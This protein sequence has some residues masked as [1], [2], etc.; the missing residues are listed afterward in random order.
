[1]DGTTDSTGVIPGDATNGLD[2][3]PT[4][5]PIDRTASG[6]ITAAAQTVSINKESG[7]GVVGI[8]IT[9][10]WT[11]TIEFE[12]TVDGS[13]WVALRVHDGTQVVTNTTANGLFMAPAGHLD[14]VRVRSS[15]Y[16][17]GTAN[18]NLLS[19][20]GVPASVITAPLPAGTNNIGDVDIA[21]ALPAGTNNIGDVDVLTQPARSHTTDSIRIGD[22]TDLALVTGAGALVVDGSGVTQP[23]SGTVSANLNAGT[24]NIGDVDIASP[25]GG[26]TEAAA[27]RVTIANDSTGVVSVDDNGGSLTVDVGSALPAGTNNI[28]DVDIASFAS[29]AITEVQGDVAHDAAVGGNP[30]L[31]G[32]RANANEPTAVADGDATHIWADTFG[33]QV[34]IVGHPSTEAP[35]TANGSAAGVSVIAAPGAGVSLH[36]CKGSVHNSAAAE[37]IVSLREGTAGTIRWT[38]NLAADGGGSLFDFGSRGWKLPA[39]TALIMDAASA[40]AYC[41]ITE[42]YIAP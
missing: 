38:V 35:V 24:N 8:Q 11:A 16:T 20:R 18:I 31:M 19:C 32:A 26:G 36:I 22:G 27:V 25:L 28:G 13:N 2:V 17:S 21:S 5:F 4:R 29:G 30:V 33:R 37:Q 39:N 23:V 7:E 15:A 9:G 41:N 6:T 34:I 14:Q 42:Y 10:T 3:D 1:M 12:G 40:T